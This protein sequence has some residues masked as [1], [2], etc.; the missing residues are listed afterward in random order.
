[1]TKYAFR[2]WYSDGRK[3][4]APD[5]TPN[6]VVRTGIAELDPK[7]NI[8]DIIDY[9]YIEPGYGRRGSG[10]T[11]LGYFMFKSTKQIGNRK[12]DYWFVEIEEIED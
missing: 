2:E 8:L 10:K 6:F 5:K 4:V 12:D 11:S 7:M 1:M 9:S 3:V